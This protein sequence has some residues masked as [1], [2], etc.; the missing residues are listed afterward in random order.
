MGNFGSKVWQMP[1]RSAR[2]DGF[3]L[4]TIIIISVILLA[5]GASTLQLASAIS[6][7]LNDQH[8]NREAKLAAQAGVSFASSC[9]SA[10]VTTWP[11]LVPNKKCDGT[12]TLSPDPGIYIGSDISANSSPGRWRSTFAVSTPV[13]GSDAVPRAN[14]TGKV[15]VL[16]SSNIVVKT[17]TYTYNAVLSI[18]ASSSPTLSAIGIG[19]N[20]A[21]ADTASC[22]VAG[23][24]Q[25]Y[26]AGENDRGNLGDGTPID[27]LTPVLFGG[28][29]SAAAG[30][31][32]TQVD[33]G[34]RYGCALTTD[35]LIF[36]TGEN[37][38]GNLG[39]SNTAAQFRPVQF[40]AGLGL[41]YI[42]VDV[43]LNHTC[44]LT[45]DQRIF[46]AGNNIDGRFGNGTSGSFSTTPLQ[47]D[48]S[49]GRKYLQVSA[50]TSHTCGLATDLYI[51]CA[52]TG[53]S[54][55]LGNGV[56]TPTNNPTPV[57]F[58]G[59]STR[60]YS[61]VGAG[62]YSTCAITTDQLIYCSGSNSFSHLG[63]GTSTSP[64]TTPTQSFTTGSAVG[65]RFTKVGTNGSVT[66]ALTTD[67]LIRCAG[68][69]S[70]Y[71]LGNST[72]G[73]F[74]DPVSFGGTQAP[75]IGITFTDV[76]VGSFYTCAIGIDQKIYCSGDNNGGQQGINNTTDTTK[77]GISMCLTLPCS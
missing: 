26:C 74:K 21:G 44:A 31:K 58:G 69:G 60:T 61:Q 67:K 15:E 14:I 68:D 59:A 48:A 34:Y 52:G 10:G 19:A 57:K 46:C 71:Q 76:S 7:S 1:K 37:T 28:P 47:F 66:C 43:G 9:L 64:T 49:S 53:N 77:P 2:E 35:Q 18:T 22:M 16:T 25:V 65:K 17:Y 39:Y 11:S 6:R 13:T 4:P 40:G 63:N 70:Q 33:V 30:K 62:Q 42:N 51:Y 8:W 55:E 50:G 12:T 36:C 38:L 23:D 73:I 5:I 20:S 41:K 32:F 56:N 75:T 3:A 72:V 29:L 54:Y 45:T 24:Q 27:K